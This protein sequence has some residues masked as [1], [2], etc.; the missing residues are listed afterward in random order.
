MAEKFPLALSIAEQR[1]N[2]F[3][4][5]PS[6]ERGE[7]FNATAPEFFIGSLLTQRPQPAYDAETS[8]FNES[9]SQLAIVGGC[10]ETTRM[11]HVD[12]AH[13]EDMRQALDALV[14]QAG[15]S[16]VGQSS[17]NA[18]YGDKPEYGYTYMACIGQSGIYIHTYPEIGKVSVNIEVCSGE[19]IKLDQGEKA[20]DDCFGLIKD[21][22]GGKTI[23]KSERQRL[24]LG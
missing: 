22:F 17:I 16:I 24:P 4:K 11:Q 5:P 15:F 3:F 6:T 7:L 21:F 18:E 23:I 14:V 8:G 13:H 20:I 10:A 12:E 2:R 9:I 19:V 1:Q